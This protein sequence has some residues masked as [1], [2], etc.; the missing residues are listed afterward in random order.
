VRDTVNS[1]RYTHSSVSPENLGTI[2]FS[3][4]S[5]PGEI[6]LSM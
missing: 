6:K 4:H 2:S 1:A 3:G 5:G